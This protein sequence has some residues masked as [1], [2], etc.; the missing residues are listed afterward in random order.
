MKHY[1]IVKFKEDVNKS[2]LIKPIENLFN[3]TLN[4]NG[5]ENVKLI[6]SNSKLPNRYDL[7]IEM[8]LTNNGLINFDKSE[9]HLKWKA[10][11]GDY[12]LSKAIFDCES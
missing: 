8:E 7:M 4:I 6:L 12:I 2:S 3:K 5:V 11:Y 1:I 9:V 10:D